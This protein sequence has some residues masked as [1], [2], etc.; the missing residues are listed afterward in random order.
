[1]SIPN[2]LP[3]HDCQRPLSAALYFHHVSRC[4]SWSTL[5]NSESCWKSFKQ[6]KSHQPLKPISR[7]VPRIHQTTSSK[8]LPKPQSWSLR[9]WMRCEQDGFSAKI[10]E[11]TDVCLLIAGTQRYISTK[12]LSHQRNWPTWIN[13]Y[14]WFAS[15]L[16]CAAMFKHTTFSN[17]NNLNKKMI[18]LTY[19]INIKSEKLQNILRTVL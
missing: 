19:Y 17:N 18:N 11:Y 15:V 12:S 5:K 8:P 2:H 16:V 10:L 7:W 9:Q 1:M 6:I 3:L 4:L 13:M 14:L